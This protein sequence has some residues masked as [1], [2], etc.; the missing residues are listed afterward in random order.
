MCS[1]REG[2]IQARGEREKKCAVFL[3]GRERERERELGLLGGRWGAWSGSIDG[4]WL[5]QEA[6]RSLS[7][8]VECVVVCVYEELN[9]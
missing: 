9:S 3:L 7:K 5:G 8:E 4:P 6:P 2:S 1:T